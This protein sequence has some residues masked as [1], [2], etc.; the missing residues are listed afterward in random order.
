MSNI[1]NKGFE[2]IGKKVK[3]GKNN[4]LTTEK[5]CQHFFGA[6]NKP[7]PL[8]FISPE[9]K[10]SGG[11]L[12]PNHSLTDMDSWLVLKDKVASYA[13]TKVNYE[14]FSLKPLGNDKQVKNLTKKQTEG[15]RRA[16]QD[17]GYHVKDIAIA[18]SKRMPSEWVDPRV[19]VTPHGDAAKNK[20]DN[21]ENF[22]ADNLGD[23]GDYKQL[24]NKL[25]YL[26]KHGRY[27]KA[28]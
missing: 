11:K 24:C 16:I 1:D 25:R 15:R 8:Y 3:A 7:S 2:L 13:L 12:L 22:I 14:L 27:S 17:V 20:I 6:G 19:K 10:K 21:L 23:L 5:M 9:V 26:I 4:L 18:M 28:T